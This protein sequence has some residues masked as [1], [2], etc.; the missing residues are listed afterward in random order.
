MYNNDMNNN[1][2]FNGNVRPLFENDFNNTTNSTNSTNSMETYN[3]NY[4]NFQNQ[5][6]ST[7]PISSNFQS[8]PI[9]PTNVFE[10]S[11]SQTNTQIN[12][13]FQETPNFNFNTQQPLGDIPPELGEIKNLS[14]ATISSAP[15]M[16]VLDP[17][18]VMPETT[19]NNDPLDN[20]ENGNLNNF[21]V[22]PSISTENM[23][24]N[25]PYSNQQI[26]D[27]NQ[28]SNQPSFNSDFINNDYN[29]NSN[30]FSTP[31][32]NSP[33]FMNQSQTNLNNFNQ[34]SSNNNNFENP[35]S[36]A[37]NQYNDFQFNQ[38]MYKTEDNSFNDQV[39][40]INSTSLGELS[41]TDSLNNSF[42]QTQSI[43]NQVSNADETKEYTI[44]QA[45]ELNK[46]EN[47]TASL[48]DLGIENAYDEP[49]SLDILDIEEPKTEQEQSLQTLSVS[50]TVEKIKNVIE[51]LKA[52]G[53]NIDLEEFDFEKMYQLIIKI[54]K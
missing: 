37:T 22:Y 47:N 9:N 43:E 15:T 16:D 28:I 30:Q 2:N 36:T 21:N 14:D 26:S 29:L 35:I 32:Q 8:Q 7:I 25:N 52:N 40:P 13:N 44:V 48:S 17:M 53:I 5:S 20:Y 31:Y 50:E 42:N 45:E 46:E 12:S 27:M 10:N 11:F 38:G 1:Q 39:M 19:N 54:D 3:P 33:S 23:P 6:S 41:S 24:L 51:E 49:D 34:G 18:N 4:Q